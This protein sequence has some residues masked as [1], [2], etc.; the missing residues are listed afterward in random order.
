MDA[1]YN[2]NTLN[3]SI[4]LNYSNTSFIFLEQLRIN[5]L[6]LHI[7]IYSAYVIHIIDRFLIL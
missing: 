5:L 4:M 6:F 3:Y 7:S 2:C 1:Y